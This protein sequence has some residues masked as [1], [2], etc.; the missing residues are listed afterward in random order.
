MVYPNTGLR[1]ARLSHDLH[2]TNT[3][4]YPQFGSL[5]QPLIRVGSGRVGS[6]RAAISMRASLPLA[7][8]VRK[9]ITAVSES[10]AGTVILSVLYE[11]TVYKHTA[12]IILS[13]LLFYDKR[14][15][16]YLIERHE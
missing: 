1:R 4:V 14:N 5:R 3:Q 10:S 2:L 16:P 8:R 7:E 12:I 6:G 11:Y 15:I 13:S 9:F